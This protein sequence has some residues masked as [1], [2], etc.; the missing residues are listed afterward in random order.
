MTRILIV[1]D[2]ADNRYLLQIL[3]A[4]HG[5]VVDTAR[6]GVEALSQA[7]QFMP[8]LVISD[9]LMPVM[10]GYSLLRE[11]KS[12]VS[13]T[14]IPFIVYTATY[15]DRADE[16][17]ALDLGADAFIIKP[18]DPM[19]FLGQLQRVLENV[20]NH[21]RS[22]DAEP[23]SVPE[24][25]DKRH[26]DVLTRKLQQKIDALEQANQALAEQ[27][28]D[29]KRLYEEQIT[30][31]ERDAALRLSVIGAEAATRA[32]SDFLAKMSHEIR[33]PM[34]AILGM[35]DLVLR[36]QLDPQQRHFLE[37]SRL[38]ARSLLKIIDDILDFSRVEAG[39]LTLENDDFALSDMLARVEASILHRVHEK[40]LE[41]VVAIEPDVPKLVR[42][43]PQRIGQILIN[44]LGN[45][46]KFS[47]AGHIV[48][49]ISC[50]TV[51]ETSDSRV[52]LKFSVQD[53][54]IG[55]T[56]EQTAKLFQPF[57]QGDGSI[58]REF[59]GSGLGLAICKQLVDLI[60]GEI[61]VISEPGHGSTFFFTIPVE[62]ADSA[63]TSSTV[64]GEARSRLEAEG[65]ADFIQQIAGKHILLVEDN[66]I[67]LMLAEELLAGV[68]GTRV[69]IAEN[70][71]EAL[72]RLQEQ[73]FDA[74]LMDLQM[75]VMDGYEAAR[76][77]RRNPDLATLPIIAVT[78]HAMVAEQEKC[79]AAGMNDYITKPFE[80]WQLFSILAK[81][82]VC[83]RVWSD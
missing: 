47:Q 26:I 56:A 77:I 55:M 29:R 20:R 42:G 61:G 74:V 71:K 1:D 9:L 52:T 10:D 41:L 64:H 7:R 13:L 22:A 57:V 54:G 38:A 67:N 75:P 4:G 40:N 19:E 3:L 30:M 24:Q 15:T 82:T 65:E 69:T 59:G 32:K 36:S 23:G 18:C 25:V 48:L 34:N 28:E 39:K 76:Q 83:D 16:K 49:G 2:V 66:P 14:G 60:G 53:R 44:L 45:A 21:S 33:T 46:A 62:P 72:D 50:E 73:R 5:Y 63:A 35:T 11:W 27:V 12:D 31:L 8:D 58:T 51:S 81:W 80:P 43:D 70:G 17:L 37:Q 68:A 79:Q 78:A 6:N